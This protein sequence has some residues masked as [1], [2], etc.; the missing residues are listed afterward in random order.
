MALPSRVLNSGVT[1]LTTAAICGEGTA[2]ITAAGS[3]I[4]D[5]V[6]LT[7]IY[8]Q[9]TTAAAGT[10]VRLPVTEMGAQIWVTN[11]GDNPLTVYPFDTNSTIGGAASNV[12]VPRGV[13]L[14]YGLSNTRWE[15][16][17]AYGTVLP[18]AY[19]SFRSD[20]RQNAAVINT[21][22]PVTLDATNEAY[23]VSIGTPAS[24][25]VC[26]LPGVYNFEFS[27]QLD[28]TAAATAHIFIWYRINGNDIANSASRF[29]INGS[30]SE[31]V[32]SWNFV[33]TMA[34]GD[35]FELVWATDDTNAFIEAFAAAA[36][37]PA[38]PSVILTATQIR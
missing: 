12:I 11:L 20:S 8:N 6:L 30:D 19:G 15:P 17:Q 35:Y 10:G 16:M 23:L 22:Y 38:I 4:T 32:A 24:R 13:A 36:P 34:A 5:A 18:A 14:Y 3:N 21:A 37:V 25:I 7:S 26:A 9:I 28:K 33:Q 2:S 29:A 1:S 31:T 27:M